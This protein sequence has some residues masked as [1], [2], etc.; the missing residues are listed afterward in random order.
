MTLAT[1]L[2]LL[3]TL[4]PACLVLGG[5]TYLGMQREARCRS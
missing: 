2:L 4:G 3:V 5:W 1:K